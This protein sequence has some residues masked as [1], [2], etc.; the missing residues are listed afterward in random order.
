MTPAATAPPLP[1]AVEVPA[2]QAAERWRA[3]RRR[4]PAAAPTAPPLPP[5]VEIPAEQVVLREEDDLDDTPGYLIALRASEAAAVAR[6]AAEMQAA[7]DAAAAMVAADAERQWRQRTSTTATVM[8]ATM[9]RVMA[10]RAMAVRA[11]SST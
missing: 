4:G 10:T 8:R 3:A 5:A 9:T 2:E 6:E 7:L 1:P 11:R